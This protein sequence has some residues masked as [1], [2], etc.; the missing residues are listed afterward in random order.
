[1]MQ[2]TLLVLAD[3]CGPEGPRARTVAPRDPARPGSDYIGRYRRPTLPVV[4]RAPAGA[5]VRPGQSM[6]SSRFRARRRRIGRIDGFDGL[7]VGERGGIGLD[8]RLA[9]IQPRDDFG[10][11]AVAEADLDRA[12]RGLAAGRDDA[13]R[14]LLLG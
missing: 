12:A 5:E 11:R 10:P 7:S 3:A 9:P 13:E 6:E 1:M 14:F 4:P 8:H 2:S